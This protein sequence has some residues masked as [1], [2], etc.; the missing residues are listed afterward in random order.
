MA[1]SHG[2]TTR[3][4]N[5]TKRF[6]S[7]EYGTWSAMKAR[8]KNPA[9]IHY[10]DYGG[11]GITVCE[12]WEKFENFLADM[13]PRPTPAHSLERKDVNRGY[14]PD[15]CAWVTWR[16][17]ARN[18]RR[19]VHVTLNGRTQCLQDWAH[20]LGINP[21]TV[22]RRLELGWGYERAL[23]EPLKRPYWGDTRKAAQ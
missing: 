14:E 4:S 3:R 7:S 9:T 17:Q 1:K 16:E 10:A 19:T 18:T 11:R 13:G 8:C 20:E 21:N 12:R 15:N 6:I 23:T 22:R 5:S 2:H